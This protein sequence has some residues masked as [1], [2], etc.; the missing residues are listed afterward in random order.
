MITRALEFDWD[1]PDM[2]VIRHNTSTLVRLLSRC[3]RGDDGLLYWDGSKCNRYGQM[4][5]RGV[6]RQAHRLAYAL[7]VGPVPADACVLHRNDEPYCLDPSVLFLGTQEDNI[8][9]MESKGRG[10]H[11]SGEN[12]GMAKLTRLKVDE[13][14]AKYKP[15]RANKPTMKDL[16]REYSVS[17]SLI[18]C[19]INNQTWR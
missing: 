4:S 16:A 1:S 9:D 15:G 19:I 10:R 12:S 11:P 18:N 2:D 17:P 7:L 13:I 5:Y 8:L 3:K 6:M 14:R